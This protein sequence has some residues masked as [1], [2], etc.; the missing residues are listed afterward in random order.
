MIPSKE[1]KHKIRIFQAIENSL[2]K[3]EETRRIFVVY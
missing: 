1:H 3:S 2:K